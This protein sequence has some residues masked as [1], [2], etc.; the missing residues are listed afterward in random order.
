MLLLLKLLQSLL[1]MTP[2]PGVSQAGY[3]S[4]NGSAAA[5]VWRPEKSAELL[6]LLLLALL[7]QGPARA[8]VAVQVAVLSHMCGVCKYS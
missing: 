8:R 5:A 2:A 1:L 3:V 6:L 4:S 7:L